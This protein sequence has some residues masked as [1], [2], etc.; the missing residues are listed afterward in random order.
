MDVRFVTGRAGSG[1]TS[2][3]RDLLVEHISADPLTARAIYLVP[4]QATFM[5]QRALAIDPRL[6]G[7]IG[8]R[9]TSPDEL[10]ELALVETGAAAGAL[11]DPVG[12]SLIIGHLLRLHADEL[13]HFGRSARQPGLAAQIDQAFGEFEHS[14]TDLADI[15]ATI[16]DQP[17]ESQLAR[18]LT[19]LRFLYQKYEEYL[20]AKQFDRRERA[21]LAPDAIARWPEAQRAMVLV[22]EFYDFTAYERQI[23]TALSKASA[24][25]RIALALDPKADVVRDANVVPDDVSLLSRTEHTYRRLHFAM[26][27][28]GVVIGQPIL[29]AERVRFG[30]SSLATVEQC[31]DLRPP[32]ATA[33]DGRVRFVLAGDANDEID[34]AAREIKRLLGKGLRLRD[35]AV[36]SRSVSGIAES[37]AASFGQHKIPFFLDRRRP[38]QHHP[39]LRTLS[40]M[41]QIV[42]TRWS[43]ES[44]FELAKA[45]L[46]G[47]RDSKNGGDKIA[48]LDSADVDLLEDYVTQHRIP[49][50]EWLSD[51]SWDYRRQTEEA[52]ERAPVFSEQE[53]MHVNAAHARLRAGL[54]IV[55][56]S[57]WL[58]PLPIRQ[59]VSDIAEALERLHVR[60][61]T[62]ALIKA[63]ESQDNVEQAAE[64]EQAWNSV[65]DVFDRFVELLGDV[66][67]P[68]VEFAQ[69]M[70][71]TLATL[72]LAI[73]PPTLDQVLVGSIDRTR[74][75]PIKAAI[76]IGMNE[77]QFPHCEQE[78]AV[79]NDADRYLLQKSGVEI[80]PPTRQSLLAER[81]LGYLALTRASEHLTLIRVERDDSGHAQAPSPF[82]SAVEAIVPDAVKERPVDPIERVATPQQAV[83]LALHNARR[84]NAAPDDET[85]GLYNWLTTKPK[86]VYETILR[87]W[88]SLLYRNVAELSP[89]VAARLYAP[90]LS[91]SVSRFESFASCPFQHFARYGLRLR[92]PMDLKLSAMDLGNLYHAVLDQVVRSAIRR[93]LDFTDAKIL[94]AEQVREAA[95]RIAAEMSEQVFLTTAQ[96]RFTV[97]QLESCVLK[98][99]RAQQT[100]LARGEFR[101]HATELVFGRSDRESL[102][103]LE[104]TTPKGNVVKL[105]GKIDRIDVDGTG[106]YFSVVDYKLAGQSLDCGYVKHGLMLQLLTY[107]LVLRQN[108]TRLTG[109][110]LTPA[111][112]LY[113][114]LLRSIESV[115]HPTEAPPPEEEAF[116]LKQKPRG[117]VSKSHIERFDRDFAANGST[118]VLNYKVKKDGEFYASGNDGIHDEQFT[119]L[120]DFVE[121]RITE[122]ADQMIDG[123]ISVSPYLI[124]NETPCQRCDLQQICRFDRSVNHYRV[125]QAHARQEA[126][127]LMT[128]VTVNGH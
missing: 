91:A 73:T 32:K 60:S 77:C 40:A 13:Q 25:C 109:K 115:D 66:E 97:E 43:H 86:P 46:I 80:D 19:D 21:A 50:T 45:G 62:L 9:V 128:K 105:R 122:L 58:D 99:L 44:V 54:Q 20:K 83:T 108:G 16:G 81:F 119:G 120:I 101:P 63:A 24:V 36:L 76:L 107:L 34:A 27:Q 57:K 15:D 87:A 68:G 2:L 112:A 121:K 59:R 38:A 89:E 117:L 104:L 55:G 92:A 67:L 96:S 72:D 8:V 33:D 49:P 14:E 95:Q 18:K 29:R 71:S 70:Q 124:A 30:K 102:P 5:T 22:D 39:L 35:I 116:H 78:R 10:A 12:R 103:A 17:A 75:G 127:D 64:H 23:I 47:V 11:L 88:P 74:T 69:L 53:L 118:D 126:I 114:R 6:G 113:V 93:R 48:M 79:L 111:A 1:K 56:N 28:N 37:V 26:L 110:P 42:L 94:S 100:M 4:K 84:G 125:L 52:G 106:Q 51:S 7:F 82:W 85:V 123:D 98:S 31:L 90:P 41:M 65:R 61:N 3:L